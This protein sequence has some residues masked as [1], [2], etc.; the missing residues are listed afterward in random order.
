MTKMQMNGLNQMNWTGVGGDHECGRNAR[1]RRS[2]TEL[3]GQIL[4]TR[5]GL[6]FPKTLEFD[7]WERAGRRL[8]HIVDSSAW[9]IGDWVAY[10]EVHFPDRYR[11][12]SD[13]TGLGYGTLRNYASVARRFP[14]SRRRDKLSF[15][16]H[17]ELASLPTAEQ[18]KWLD[19]AER[20]GWSRSQLRH[21]LRSSRDESAGLNPADMVVRKFSFSSP[22]VD[23]WRAAADQAGYEFKEWMVSTLDAAANNVLNEH[24]T[25]S[26]AG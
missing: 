14:V 4:V 15:Q 13:T 23:L 9:C 18:D 26:L 17:A 16:H 7:C 2:R 19:L 12:A 20:E 5:V 1:Q 22:S 24:V 25:D 8:M 21:Q 6:K 10:G 3:G 11:R